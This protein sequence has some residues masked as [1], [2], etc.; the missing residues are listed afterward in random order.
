MLT[1][2]R[3]SYD[4]GEQ[5]AAEDGDV[6]GFALDLNDGPLTVVNGTMSG[7][8]KSRLKSLNRD[9]Y[10]VVSVEGSVSLRVNIGQFPFA[11]SV[12]DGFSSV[13][14][15]AIRQVKHADLMVSEMKR[16]C[17]S[18][19]PV[20]YGHLRNPFTCAIWP[21]AHCAHLHV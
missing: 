6:I 18:E 1:R 16:P 5:D 15:C 10:P 17:L 2:R 8:I 3:C 12:P 4:I 14:I 21:H 9:A 13:L 19:A 20:H 11:H 7:Q